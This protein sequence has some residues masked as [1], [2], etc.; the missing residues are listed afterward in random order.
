MEFARDD[1]VRGKPELLEKIG[2]EFEDMINA[3]HE[4][5]TGPLI[6]RMM[7]CK[8]EEE[9]DLVVKEYKE[10]NEKERRVLIDQGFLEDIE[11]FMRSISMEKERR[12]QAL[13]FVGAA[14]EEAMLADFEVKRKAQKRKREQQEEGL[15]VDAEVKGNE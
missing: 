7:K 15:P 3:Y 5:K 9:K 1:F 11:N 13:V 12:A 8:S 10:E 4:K 2:Q 14:E 6:E